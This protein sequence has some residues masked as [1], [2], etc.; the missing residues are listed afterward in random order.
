MN[1]LL[2]GR[3]NREVLFPWV[4]LDRLRCSTSV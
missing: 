2:A 4:L 1:E 3:L